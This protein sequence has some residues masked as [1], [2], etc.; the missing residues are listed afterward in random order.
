MGNHVTV[1]VI[2]DNKLSVKHGL[3]EGEAVPAKRGCQFVG[4]KFLLNSVLC[5]A[6][7]VF[8]IKLLY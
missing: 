2:R 6:T 3:E 1:H 4:L 7:F 8:V 5:I